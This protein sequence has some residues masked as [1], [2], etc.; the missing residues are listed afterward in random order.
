MNFPRCFCMPQSKPTVCNSHL[1]KKKLTN[2][3]WRSFKQHADSN[4]PNF[5]TPW[6]D[7]SPGWMY[8]FLMSIIKICKHFLVHC[9]FTFLLFG[10]TNK[11]LKTARKIIQT[12]VRMGKK[13]KRN[14]TEGR[15]GGEESC[16]SSTMMS[17]E[18]YYLCCF[19]HS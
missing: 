15:G 13:A 6:M 7:Q 19:G 16:N 18:L 8:A 10:E 2:L 3:F 14:K 4:V 12:S 1:K 11:V 9:N 5:L 17:K